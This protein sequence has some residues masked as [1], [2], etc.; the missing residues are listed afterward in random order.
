MERPD[1]QKDIHAESSNKVREALNKV[2]NAKWTDWDLHVPAVLWA[3]RTACKNLTAQ[4]SPRLEYKS[5]V[6]SPIVH[7]NPRPCMIAP[8]DMMVRGTLEEEIQQGNSRL[9]ELEEERVQLRKKSALV[10][11][12]VMKLEDEIKEDFLGKN[13]RVIGQD[14]HDHDDKF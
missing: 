12:E 9:Q 14:A 1:T 3:Y 5:N 7:E 8:A 2:H 4:A 11:A 13:P 6:I 10:D